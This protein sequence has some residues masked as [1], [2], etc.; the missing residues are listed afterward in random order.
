M[1]MEQTPRYGVAATVTAPD[2]DRVEC[3]RQIT[4]QMADLYEKKN[5]DYRKISVK[6]HDFSR[7]MKAPQCFF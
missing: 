2:K 4:E 3:F 6:A 5:K 1:I 7:G